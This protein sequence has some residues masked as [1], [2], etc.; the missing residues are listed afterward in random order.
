M[1]RHEERH[2]RNNQGLKAAQKKAA[3][4]QRC[5]VMTCCHAYLG[6]APAEDVE[7]EEVNNGEPVVFVSNRSSMRRD[8]AG[9]F[10]GVRTSEGNRRQDR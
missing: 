5:K 1:H 10:D 9:V 8:V 2:S 6:N 7:R 4:E 3:N